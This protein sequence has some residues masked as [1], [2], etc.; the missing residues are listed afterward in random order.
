LR[1]LSI[2]TYRSSF[3]PFGSVYPAGSGRPDASRHPLPS[4]GSPGAGSPASTV[5]WGAMTAATYPNCSVSLASRYR[6]GVLWLRSLRARDAGPEGLDIP[7]WAVPTSWLVRGRQRLPGSWGT[8]CACAVL[9]HPA[10]ASTLHAAPQRGDAALRYCDA[11]GPRIANFEAE[12]YGSHTPYLRLTARVAPEPRK[13]RFRRS[14]TLPGG[15]GYPLGSN[16]R[17]RRIT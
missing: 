2:P 12:L 11:T 3:L 4:A 16:E 13:T 1:W 15:I 14:P 17:F 9:L 8:P 10:R 6:T 7:S 5:L